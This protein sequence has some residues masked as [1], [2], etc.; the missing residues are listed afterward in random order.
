MPGT[1]QAERITP[2]EWANAV[3]ESQGRTPDQHIMEPVR[4]TPSSWEVQV[5]YWSSRFLLLFLLPTPEAAPP[6]AWGARGASISALATTSQQ[7]SHPHARSEPS[8]PLCR[9]RGLESAQGPS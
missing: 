7:T 3:P 9:V 1:S 6:G 2:R 5:S 4:G 8:L